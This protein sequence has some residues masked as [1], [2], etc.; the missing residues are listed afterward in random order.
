M[1]ISRLNDSDSGGR[2]HAFW[3]VMLVSV[4]SALST[5]SDCPVNRGI[6]YNE[7]INQPPAKPARGGGVG[8]C[9]YYVLPNNMILTRLILRLPLTRPRRH[10]R[11]IKRRRNPHHYICCEQLRPVVCA[12]RDLELDLGLPDLVH[13]HMHLERQV[14]VLGAA[15]AHELKLPIR[16]NEADDAVGVEFPELHAL[17]ELAVFKRDGAGGGAGG[18]RRGWFVGV[19]GGLGAPGEPVAVEEEAVVETEFTLWGA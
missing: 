2:D 6:L 18:F 13:D 14:H 19:V 4:A 7:N 15:V 8:M 1:N 11:G 3:F 16:W 9:G 12:Y 17:V 10:T 5:N